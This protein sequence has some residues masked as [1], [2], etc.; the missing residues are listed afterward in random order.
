MIKTPPGHAKSIQRK[1]KPFILGLRNVSCRTYYNTDD[2]TILWVLDAGP[3]HMLAIN[4]NV[5]LYGSLIN[6]IFTNKKIKRMLFSKLS[7][8]DKQT[9]KDMLTNQTTVE[10][11]KNN[12]KI[13][14]TDF[15]SA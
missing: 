6:S 7:E 13:D 8:T 1:I 12:Q 10:C 11:I 5:A 4:R 14:M 2:S 3:K 15:T 9:L